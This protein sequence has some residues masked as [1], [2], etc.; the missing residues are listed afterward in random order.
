MATANQ[1]AGS[2][3]R[4]TLDRASDQRQAGSLTKTTEV[5]LA[6]PSTPE[7][8]GEREENSRRESLL[9]TQET[10]TDVD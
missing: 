10:T 8:G 7:G 3:G 6:S 1:S 5:L 4:K 2:S 9:R